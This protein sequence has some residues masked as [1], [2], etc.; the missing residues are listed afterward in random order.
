VYNEIFP[1]RRGRNNKR[2]IHLY[3]GLFVFFLQRFMRRVCLF[4]CLASLSPQLAVAGEETFSTF[5]E[6]FMLI[7]V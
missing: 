4:S 1:I 5:L 2:M 7:V 6:I 3:Y